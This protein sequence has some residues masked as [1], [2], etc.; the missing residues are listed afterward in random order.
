[1]D[2]DILFLSGHRR[3]V[4]GE[5][6]LSCRYEIMLRNQIVH[7]LVISHFSFIPSVNDKRYTN[8]A[9]QHQCCLCEL[10]ERSRISSR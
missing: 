1:M 5:V 3:A 9:A 8:E 6:S 4:L 7:A 2:I 10:R